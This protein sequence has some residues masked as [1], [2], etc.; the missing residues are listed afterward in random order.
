MLTCLV[1][2]IA[3]IHCEYGHWTRTLH[4]PEG[5]DGQFAQWTGACTHHFST[6]YIWKP[7]SSIRS[8]TISKRHLRPNQRSPSVHSPCSLP[9]ADAVVEPER[10]RTPDNLPGLCRAR[11]ERVGG[12][13]CEDGAR[14]VGIKRRNGRTGPALGLAM[15]SEQSQ[16]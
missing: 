2:R 4:D 1:R 15:A 13:E 9:H 14:T 10:E 3:R 12:R 7:T 5:A 16:A 11:G 6:A 8:A